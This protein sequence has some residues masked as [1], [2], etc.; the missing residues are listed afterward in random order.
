MAAASRKHDSRLTID[1]LLELT[2]E[3]M[4]WI[5]DF[6]T[7]ELD[8]LISDITCILAFEKR[9]DSSEQPCKDMSWDVKTQALVFK[10][11]EIE[12]NLNR[13]EVRWLDIVLIVTADLK[14]HVQN[15]LEQEKHKQGIRVNIQRGWRMLHGRSKKVKNILRMWTL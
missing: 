8:S 2:M 12:V 13:L 1:Q 11:A 15:K 14:H 4:T 5:N 10:M 6:T 3:T 9:N 7:Q